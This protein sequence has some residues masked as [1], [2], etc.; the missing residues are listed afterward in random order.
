[1]H[2]EGMD[3]ILSERIM[4]YYL[5]HVSWKCLATA[6]LPHLLQKL[7]VTQP[8]AIKVQW[9]LSFIS[10]VDIPGSANFSILLKKKE[11]L[12]AWINQQKS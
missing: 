6:A 2:E 4:P 8:T 7:S 3:R 10:S 1:M 5:Q 11:S 12:V 9:Q